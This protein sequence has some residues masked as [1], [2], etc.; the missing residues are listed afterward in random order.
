MNDSG[1][2]KKVLKN[3]LK[4]GIE[5]PLMIVIKKLNKKYAIHI[6]IILDKSLES[7]IKLN[8]FILISGI[9]A[10]IKNKQVF[11]VENDP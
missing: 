11:I 1:I 5:N 4:L 2:N 10:S 6:K 9:I 8:F 3:N 7:G